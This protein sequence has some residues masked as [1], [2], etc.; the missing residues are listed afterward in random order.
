MKNIKSL[1]L[2]MSYPVYWSEYKV[3]RDF[4]QNFYDAKGAKAWWRD[5]SYRFQEEALVMKMRNNSFSYEWLLHI[6]ASS[7]SEDDKTA[8]YFGEGFKIAALCAVRDYQWDITMSSQNWHL[9]VVEEDVKIDG[10][11]KKGL[12]YEIDFGEQ[13]EDSVLIIGNMKQEQFELFKIVLMSFFY[14]ENPLLGEAIYDDG[15]VAVYRKSNVEIPK[16]LPITGE[17]GNSGAVFAR[18][19]MLGTLP[20]DIIIAYHSF[21][22]KDRERNKL[23][24]QDI[25]KILYKVAE[26][27]NAS[28]AILLLSYMKSKWNSYPSKLVDL[29]TWYYVVCQLIRTIAESPEASLQFKELYPNLLYTKRFYKE[30]IRLIN[31]RRQ[32]R[33]WLNLQPQ[34]YKIVMEQFKLLGYSELEAVCESA[35]GFADNSQPNEKEM[36][37]I[38]I[39]ENV[40]KTIFSNF[41]L[42]KESIP[43]RII[44]K[45][46]VALVGKA[47]VVKSKVTA[48]NA[49]GLQARQ[50]LN[51]IAIKEECFQ[52]EAFPEAL[53]VYLHEMSHM[54]GGDSS[55]NFSRALTIVSKL[56]LANLDVVKKYKE[57]WEKVCR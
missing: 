53:A 7:K 12:A 32:A 25:L 35:G 16:Q 24:R 50:Q 54:F 9:H 44:R 13:S 23:Y 11:E 30:D 3:I 49:Y 55:A 5:F 57:E 37:Y 40:K 33:A 29:F 36:R 20:F 2:L 6:G 21:P 41:F 45:E 28:T 17:Y 26:E 39:L 14:P 19:Q 8:G 46:N 15:D 27:V 43:F 34:K 56:L 52:K 42:G 48:E 51:S 18:Y 1:N 47:E 4:V 22:Q 38:K 31:R 10:K